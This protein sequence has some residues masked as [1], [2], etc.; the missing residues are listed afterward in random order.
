MEAQ[1]TDDLAEVEPPK[2]ARGKKKGSNLTDAECQT[3]AQEL[4]TKMQ[5]AV[6]DDNANNLKKMPA[7]KKYLLVEEVSRQLRRSAIS[8]VFIENGGCGLLGQWLEPLPDGTF[9][10]L[11]V[12][13]E[14]L[15]TIDLLSIGPDDLQTDKNLGRIVKLYAKNIP[16]M[17]QVVP[18]AKKIMDRWSR[19]VFGIKTNYS[20]DAEDDDEGDAHQEQYKRLKRKLQELKQ[21]AQTRKSDDSE[22]ENDKAATSNENSE[23]KIR[24]P[25]AEQVVR[26]RAGIIMPAKNAFDFIEK[27]QSRDIGDHRMA[28]GQT[29]GHEKLRKVMSTLKKAGRPSGFSSKMAIA[30]IFD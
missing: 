4:A 28:F 5:R 30:K 14:V 29:K 2:E 25:K 10:N 22:D 17:P 24:E 8:N 9:P 26:S 19:L 21:V 11:T 3:I 16:N 18:L 13:Q 23:P 6:E 7:L 15:A 27:P 1:R 20:R 12:V